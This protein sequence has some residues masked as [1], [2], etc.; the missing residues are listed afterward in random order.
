MELLGLSHFVP[1][2]GIKQVIL[3]SEPGVRLPKWLFTKETW[4]VDFKVHATSL[5]LDNSS[6]WGI[7]E[8]QIDG[9][10]ISLSCPERAILEMLHLVPSKQSFDEMVLLMEGLRQLRPQVVQKLLE[11]CKSIKVKRL[12]LYLAERFQHPW[13]SELELKKID[14]GHGKR[15]IGEG[16]NYDAKYQISVPKITEE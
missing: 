4:K 11:K 8:Q 13:L 15:V 5:F 6:N 7:I 16:G 3:F 2:H 14:L 9:I 10:N 1:I 12:F